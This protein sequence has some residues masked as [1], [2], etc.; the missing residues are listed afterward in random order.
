MLL[1]LRCKL[2]SNPILSAITFVILHLQCGDT[3]TD[4]TLNRRR[5]PSDSGL[6]RVISKRALI[7][8][9]S[10][11]CGE[12]WRLS[13]FSS[14]KALLG[15]CVR[16]LRK[17]TSVFGVLD[18]NHASACQCLGCG[19]YPC[20][21]LLAYHFETSSADR[22]ADMGALDNNGCIFPANNS[23]VSKPG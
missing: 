19:R 17:S 18:P 21:I 13:V 10:N 7:S 9:K 16:Q 12:K 2:N 3:Y 23:G 20:R 6:R 8:S 11:D 1:K 5:H 22:I 4:S 14:G 15:L